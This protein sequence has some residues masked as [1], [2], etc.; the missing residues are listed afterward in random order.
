MGDVVPFKRK[1]ASEQ[2][3]KKILCRSNLHKWVVVKE[4]QFDVKRGKLVTLYRCA[5]CGATKTE[6][7]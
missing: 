1:T 2:H 7:H 3:G 5:R 4:N 6:A